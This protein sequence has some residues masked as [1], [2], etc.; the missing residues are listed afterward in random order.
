MNATGHTYIE[1]WI[2]LQAQGQVYSFN[3]RTIT[4]GPSSNIH[5]WTEVH[6]LVSDQHMLK[7]CS[8]YRPEK[9][10]KAVQHTTGKRMTC[11]NT[12]HFLVKR[13]SIMINHKRRH[14]TNTRF[15][16]TAVLKTWYSVSTA[17]ELVMLSLV[18]RAT[19]LLYPVRTIKHQRW[20]PKTGNHDFFFQSRKGKP[21]KLW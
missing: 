1:L 2:Y 10:L 16:T 19:F 11:C 17:L 12:L 5:R 20:V 13:T 14:Q 7:H 8:S 4:T 9:P 15:P 21:K 6:G 3:T 18:L